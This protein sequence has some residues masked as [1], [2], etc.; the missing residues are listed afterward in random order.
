MTGVLTALFTATWSFVILP[1]APAYAALLSPA[2]PADSLI[3]AAPDA[4]SDATR[5]LAGHLQSAGSMLDSGHGGPDAGTLMADRARGV[6]SGAATAEVERWLSSF[7]T[8]RVRVDVDRDFTLKN[9]E[10][11][12]LLPWYQTPA[13]V[14]FTQQS[15]H[16]TDDRTQMNL[17]AGARHFGPEWMTGVNAFYDHDLSRYHSRAGIGAELWRDYLKFGANGYLRLSSWRSAPELNHDY[18]AR[19]ANG[20]DIRAEG[21]LPAYPQLGAKMTVEQYYGKEVALFGRNSRQE[22]PHAITAGLNW[23][24]VPLV[25]AS[26]EHRAGK[27]GQDDSRFGLQLTWTPG[28]SLAQHL[29]PDA[30]RERRTL[31]GS[32]LDLVERNNNIVLEYRK[33]ELVK[34][35]LRA[36]AEGVAGQVFSLVTGLQTKYPLQAIDW[37]A[38]EFLAAGGKISGTGAGTQFTLP[39]WRPGTTAAETQRLNS[40]TVSGVARDSQGN[41]SARAQSV[42]VVQDAGAEIRAGNLTASSGARANGTDTNTVTALVTDSAGQPV[43]GEMVTFTL[44]AGVSP[45]GTAM[46]RSSQVKVTADGSGVAALNI[47]SQAAGTYSIRAAVGSGAAQA[48]TTTFVQNTGSGPQDILNLNVALADNNAMANGQATNRV[49]AV[50]KDKAGAVLAGEQVHFSVNNA[51]VRL[52]AEDV[53]TDSSG[54]AQVTLTAT[55]AGK[56]TVTASAGG[57]VRTVDVSF[58]QVQLQ[59]QLS[60]SPQS[61]PA[62]NTTPS[63][64]TLML[65]DQNNVPQPGQAVTFSVSGV[66]GTTVTGVTDVGDGTYTATL[67]G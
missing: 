15:L 21:W 14:V 12:L 60:A 2:P 64:L 28:M 41:T 9:S 61:I 65:T 17:G 19:P 47:V 63:N 22:N 18:E 16:R 34:L 20:W 30:V 52:S 25:T 43:S 6:T 55:T 11:G 37:S 8:A 51:A 62:D 24:P 35:A 44:P 45:A 5:T 54:V 53:V 46:A 40:Y 32:R 7:G 26:A 29:D 33:K 23:T 66:A 38:G 67:K 1:L 42:L 59:G 57:S 39:A 50:V 13:W 31:A 4:D 10:L 36:R 56:Y 49:R 58:T 48:A 27:G 3:T